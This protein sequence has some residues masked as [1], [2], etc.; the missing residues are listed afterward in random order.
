MPFLIEGVFPYKYEL[1]KSKNFHH[2]V[3][4]LQTQP[5]VNHAFFIFSGKMRPSLGA[6]HSFTVLPGNLF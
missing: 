6:M 2:H 3:R 4:L 1:L 5:P